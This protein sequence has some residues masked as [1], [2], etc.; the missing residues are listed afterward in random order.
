MKLITILCIALGL[1]QGCGKQ[2]VEIEPK[3][4]GKSPETAENEDETEISLPDP[5]EGMSEEEKEAF[6]KLLAKANAGD[7]E[8]QFQ[9]AAVWEKKFSLDLI[10]PMK[11][12]KIAPFFDQL[13]KAAESKDEKRAEELQKEIDLLI[14]KFGKKSER[15][16][17]L[18]AVEIKKWLT[19]AAE[20]GHLLAMGKLAYYHGNGPGPVDLAESVKWWRKAADLGD[21][22]GQLQLGILYLN[23]KGVEKDEKK[24]VELWTKA[25]KQGNGDAAMLLRLSQ[26]QKQEEAKNKSYS[27]E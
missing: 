9:V 21:A 3:V 13:F 20:Q 24:A 23:G 17:A 19:K 26:K 15:S 2:P 16:F 11:D 8:S 14:T 18:L 1:S 7:A 22:N 4:V 5:I 10:D 27:D 12:P 25:A 6:K